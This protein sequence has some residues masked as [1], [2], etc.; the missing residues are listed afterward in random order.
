MTIN[1]KRNSINEENITESS[2]L[3]S[4]KKV[5]TLFRT[6]EL[7]KLI[8]KK[9][10]ET[11]K[12]GIALKAI[13]ISFPKEERY[14]A[15]KLLNDNFD[16]QLT[17]AQIEEFKSCL[18]EDPAFNKLLPFTQKKFLESLLVQQNGEKFVTRLMEKE[19]KDVINTALRD[20]KSRQI[21]KQSQV[22]ATNRNKLSLAQLRLSIMEECPESRLRLNFFK[23]SEIKNRYQAIIT[24]MKIEE[25]KNFI[26]LFPQNDVIKF[27]NLPM[28]R[29]QIEAF[30]RQNGQLAEESYKDLLSYFKEN[31]QKESVKKLLRSIVSPDINTKL[32]KQ[33]IFKTINTKAEC[34]KRLLDI[35]AS[36]TIF[37]TR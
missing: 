1:I 29:D 14:N 4:L 3:Y 6:S 8:N 18:L 9:K 31:N 37:R 21:N 12:L 30:H 33:G 28:I 34:P 27:L 25:F 24:S 5:S 23:R 17:S 11:P 10:S 15:L 22:K 2:L 16:I 35:I 13:I 32:T 19:T 26:E 36:H 20:T 7:L